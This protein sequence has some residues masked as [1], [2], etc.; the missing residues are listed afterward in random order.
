VRL[1]QE[2]FDAFAGVPVLGLLDARGGTALLPAAATAAGLASVDAALPTLVDRLEALSDGPLH[3]AA[4]P[5]P[6]VAEIPGAAQLAGDLVDLAQRLGRPSGLYRL[7]DLLVEYQLTRPGPARD[8]LAHKL[9]PVRDQPL[10]VDTLRTYLAN[11]RQRLRTADV[12]HVHPNTLGYRLGRIAA[13]T[14]LDPTKHAD[15]QILHAALTV[16]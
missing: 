10:L 9:D 13:L 14:G 8:A 2:E 11:E 12:L 5:A 3:A 6:T 1:L 4:A 7:D 15:S 16:S